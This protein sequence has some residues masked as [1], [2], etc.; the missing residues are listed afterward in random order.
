MTTIID[1]ITD[2]LTARADAYMNELLAMG[3]TKDP[4]AYT[5]AG[6]RGVGLSDEALSAMYVEDDMAARIVNLPVRH[7][8][9]SGWDIVLPGSPAEAADLRKAYLDLEQELGVPRAL[10]A[11][12]AIGRLRGGAVTW[13]GVDDGLGDE[14]FLE[15]QAT[16]LDE[17]RI[18]RVL[19]LHTFAKKEVQHETSYTDPRSPRYR[20][21]AQYRITPEVIGHRSYEPLVSLGSGIVVHESRV[22]AWPG[23][24][25][26]LE[27]RI[28]RGGWD[29]SVLERAWDSLRAAAEDMGAKSRTLNRVSQFVFFMKNLAQLI[30]GGEAKLSRRLELINGQRRAGNA[31]VMD[32]DERVE[33]ITQPFSGL[34][35]V[36]EQDVA[37]VASAG[38]IPPSVFAG[39]PNEDEQ[40]AWDEE[41]LSYRRDVLLPRHERITKIILASKAGPA[42]GIEPETWDIVYRP[43]HEPPPKERAELRKLRAETDAIEIDKGIIPP[44]AVALH[45]HTTSSS[46]E[47]EVPLD[48]GEVDAALARRRN[49]AKQPPKDNA[50]LGTV[51][52]RASA[53]MDV[54]TK[55]AQRQVPR[56][57]GLAILT[58]FFRLTPEDAETMLGPEAF[59]PAPPPAAKPGPAPEPAKGVGAG[60]PQGLPGFDDGGNPKTKALPPPD[61]EGGP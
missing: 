44:E 13:I 48:K 59:E 10:A 58:Q 37:R 60:A 20:E 26:E 30:V 9:R 49:L 41:L 19:F 54:V 53:A 52:A 5:R 36:I 34:D 15:R 40:R 39:K 42:K 3:G 55:V 29:D 17:S 50:E 4:T 33:Q 28:L 23:A 7:A 6:S 11:G 8:L 35:A 25:T 18:E 45:R 12:M 1:S 47:G 27:R 21:T 22:I 14:H 57:T 56:E 43:L 61:P 31:L 32:L 24:E 51:G 46:G 38:G 16:P 2:A